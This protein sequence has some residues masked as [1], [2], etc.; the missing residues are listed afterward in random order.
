MS[1]AISEGAKLDGSYWWG[2]LDGRHGTKTVA[3]LEAEGYV[4]LSESPRWPGSWWMWK[5][6]AK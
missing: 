3:E 2:T 4:K 5:E 1:D 6:E